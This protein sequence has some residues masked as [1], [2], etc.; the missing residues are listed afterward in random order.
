MQPPPRH[1]IFN[2]ENIIRNLS[3]GRIIHTIIYILAIRKA[4]IITRPS[5]ERMRIPTAP[6]Y[7]K[8]QDENQNLGST[9]QSSRNQI[10]ILDKESRS[11]PAQ[12]ILREESDGEV[13]QNGGV[14]TNEQPTHVPEN[15]GQVDV[16]E[17]AD[18]GEPIRQPERDRHDE[19]DEIGDSD[20]LVPRPNREHIA[21]NGPRD[22]EG[23]VLLDVLPGPDVGAFDGG[24]DV[25]LIGDDDLHDDVVED[26][27]DDGTDH[28]RGEGGFGR[29]VGELGDFEIA[30]E[31]LAL[32]DAVEA[33]DGE[34]HVC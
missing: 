16:L 25:V 18:L 3:I 8:T 10:V 7:S 32:L 28:L 12:V 29:E 34:V 31:P 17:E 5:W 30:A 20:P 4:A 24:Q 15:D 19:A 1:H 33:E 27:A 9:I 26:G 13:R 11:V 23:V 6:K 2:A 22:R 14:D 21:G